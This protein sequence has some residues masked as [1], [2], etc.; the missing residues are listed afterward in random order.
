M[1][2]KEQSQFKLKSSCT[3]TLPNC[4]IHLDPHRQN[5]THNEELTEWMTQKLELKGFTKKQVKLSKR[6]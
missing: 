3:K 2:K 1:K 4:V 6:K 5:L